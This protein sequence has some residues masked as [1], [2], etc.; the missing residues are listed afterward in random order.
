MVTLDKKAKGGPMGRPFA[1][2]VRLQI[3]RGSVLGSA[4]PSEKQ[5]NP[6]PTDHP[7]LWSFRRCPYAMRAR[8][9][10]LSAGIVV[11]LREIKLRDKPEAFL[12]TSPTATV[13][14][15]RDGDQVLDESLDIM[16]W[17]L[18]Q[19]DPLGLMDVADEA[20]DLISANDG[21][22]K[23]ALD[24]T[25]YVTRYPDCDPEAE[26]AKAVAHLMTL[27]DRLSRGPW[28]IGDRQT[29]ADLAILPFV[30]Q[31]AHIDRDWFDA[32]PWPHLIAWLDRFLESEAFA[33]VMPKYTPWQ[34]G[35]APVLFGA[36]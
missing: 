15:L 17:A 30:R 12:Q 27:E 26:R 20:W 33:R 28:L 16:I 22:F 24:R 19:N 2:G 7:I 35:D 31:F 1:F 34:D 10:I 5:R 4:Q 11:Q 14:A 8:L 6:V 9:G 29:I 3:L 36:S 25:K 32:Q 23:R 13:P 18:R 21:P